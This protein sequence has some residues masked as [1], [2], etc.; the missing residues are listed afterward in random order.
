MQVLCS[1]VQD[2]YLTRLAIVSSP[3]SGN[4]WTRSILAKGLGLEDLAVHDYRDVGPIPERCAL[5]IHWYR[6]P[7]FQQFLTRGRFS[8]LAIAR[9]PLDVLLSV[10]HFAPHEP[11]TNN[12]LLGDCCIPS[13]FGEVAPTST[14]FLDYCLSRGAENLLLITYQWW[15]D[16]AAI[17]VRYEDL[18]RDPVKAFSGIA[19][20][21]G[22]P[23]NGLS[24]A[25]DDINL[26][27]FKAAP[28]KHGWRGSPG[29]WRT[30]I[31][32]SIARRVE[33]RHARIFDVL[34]YSIPDYNLDDATARA[35]WERL[36]VPPPPGAPTA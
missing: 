21:L 3:R 36:R 27:S 13:S 16:P 19:T 30:M 28:N 12:W 24:Q 32:R 14:E 35:T 1:V 34:G 22:E 10:L 31:P 15:H 9:H 6:E 29:H 33:Q 7:Q 20:A 2:E 26:A 8:I 25:L 23:T 18:V 11:A 4:S 5:Q 17:K